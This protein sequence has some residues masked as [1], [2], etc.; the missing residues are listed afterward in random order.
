MPRGRPKKV[1]EGA[2]APSTSQ[3]DGIV[4]HEQPEGHSVAEIT[5]S[6]PT[7]TTKKVG[8]LDESKATSTDDSE[9]RADMAHKDDPTSIDVS[10]SGKP[11]KKTKVRLLCSMADQGASYGYGEEVELDADHADRLIAS[12]GAEKP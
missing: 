9:A 7:A 3:A 2:K 12:G 4:K 1:E 6:G 5:N 8:I 10:V 11:K